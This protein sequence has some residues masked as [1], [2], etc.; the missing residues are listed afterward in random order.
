MYDDNNDGGMREFQERG[1]QEQ[2]EEE[3]DADR[4]LHFRRMQQGEPSKEG[5]VQCMLL[6]ESSPEDDGEQ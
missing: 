1:A 6:K 5:A 3:D 2:Q 4:E